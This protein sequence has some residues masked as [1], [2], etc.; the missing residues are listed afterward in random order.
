MIRRIGPTEIGWRL[1][2][3]HHPRG[4]QLWVPWDR[5]AGIIGPQGSGKTLD[6]LI[7]ALLAAPGAVAAT[8]QL[9]RAQHT[10]SLPALLDE[11]AQSF[12]GALRGSEAGAGLGAFAKRQPAPWSFE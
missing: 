5:T 3:A 8:K 6:L 7:P 2:R 11:A 12:A 9:L 4:G 10:L 1:G